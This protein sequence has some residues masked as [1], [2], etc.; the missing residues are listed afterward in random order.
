MKKWYD[1]N[2]SIMKD[3]ERVY[4]TENDKYIDYLDEEYFL[5]KSFIKN[6]TK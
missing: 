3:K 4:K 6:S 5:W 1:E 2:K